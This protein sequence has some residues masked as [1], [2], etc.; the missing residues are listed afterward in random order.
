VQYIAEVA[1][2]IETHVATIGYLHELGVPIVAG[3]DAG[4][5]DTGF[6]DFFEE[7]QYLARAGLSPLEAIHAATGRAAE[8]CQLDGVIGTLTEGRVADLV[9]VAGDPLDDLSNLRNPI[10]VLQ[11]GSIV[12]D[13]R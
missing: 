7:L 10:I 6:D 13:R 8:A 11:S 1:R 5:R 9:A 2:T 4:W 12:V 3:S